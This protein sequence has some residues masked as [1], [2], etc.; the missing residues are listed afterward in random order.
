MTDSTL[1]TDQLDKLDGHQGDAAKH[2]RGPASATLAGPSA[3]QSSPDAI[4]SRPEV[5]TPK[6]EA[7]YELPEPKPETRSEP[8]S[9]KLE[10]RGVTSH[11]S[12]RVI[13]ESEIIHQ[14]SVLAKLN[15]FGR[16]DLAG[17]LK[18]CHTIQTVKVC[19][20]CNKQ[21]SF[22]NR[23]ELFFCPICAP[24][25]SRER[26]QSIEW[27]TKQIHQPK[28][29]VLT[30]RNAA[31][32]TK[33]YVQNLKRQLA[34]LRRQ[35]IFAG[36]SGGFYSIEV[37]NE[38]RG[39]H[40]HI[41]LLVN[42]RWIPA[43]KLAKVWGNLVGQNFAIVKVKDCSQTDYLREVTKYAVKGSELAKWSG[44]EIAQ[45]IEAFRGVRLFG[46]FGNLYGK[47][48]EWSAWI[49]SIREIRPQCTCGCDTWRLLSP[50]EL[51]W[52]QET[53][54]GHG[55]VPPPAPNQGAPNQLEIRLAGQNILAWA[56]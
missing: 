49:A 30:V 32:L 53:K 54:C 5:G 10:T 11:S 18:T 21:S 46:V 47:R 20:S 16:A 27:W 2:I 24:R 45:F 33:T 4:L 55:G 26:K 25:L 56:S 19:T 13:W 51:L 34:R 36:V 6:P 37:T 41:H 17:K 1:Q 40:V 50:E 35:N 39:W 15:E 38:G 42:A 22:Y 14:K 7:W 48:T 43:D 23:C 8:K 9:L 29:V 12:Q 52:E 3:F 28:H 44:A 31:Q